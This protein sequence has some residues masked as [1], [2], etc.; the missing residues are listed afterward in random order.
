MTTIAVILN[1]FR[2]P[3]LFTWPGYGT[4]GSTSWDRGIKAA[5]ASVLRVSH[6]RRVE[7]R[8]KNTICREYT[9]SCLRSV[10]YNWFLNRL[11]G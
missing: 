4:W 7:P 11:T 1:S 6:G 10:T 9:S 2:G 8:A 5:E 3:R